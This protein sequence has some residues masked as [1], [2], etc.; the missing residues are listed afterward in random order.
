MLRMRRFFR[1][2]RLRTWRCGVFLVKK[3]EDDR[4]GTTETSFT[5]ER[6]LRLYVVITCVTTVTRVSQVHVIGYFSHTNTF[7]FTCW[8][9]L[10]DY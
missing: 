2:A 5:F 4:C 10:I 3:G 8:N 1:L 7:V 6:L 9:I